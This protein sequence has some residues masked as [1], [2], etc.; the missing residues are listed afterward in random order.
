MCICVFSCCPIFAGGKSPRSLTQTALTRAKVREVLRK[1]PFPG[2]PQLRAEIIRG[3][4][5][6]PAKEFFQKLFVGG[7][8]TGKSCTVAVKP[9]NIVSVSFLGNIDIPLAYT[10]SKENPT[11]IFLN[12]VGDNQILIVQHVHGRAVSVTY[13]VYDKKGYA[14]FGGY[15]KGDFIKECVFGVERATGKKGCGPGK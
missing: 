9:N 1:P 5:S 11:D 13:T 8:F 14:V 4:V 15:G 12:E 10:G 3:C 7:R 2:A 6:E